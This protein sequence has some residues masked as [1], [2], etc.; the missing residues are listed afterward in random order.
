M[1]LHKLTASMIFDVSY[2][3]VTWDE[4]DPTHWISLGTGRHAMRKWGKEANHALN[5]DMG[6]RTASIRWECT[7]AEAKMIIAAYHRMYPGVRKYQARIR[8]ELNR[9]HSVLA[10]LHGRKRLFMDR[11]GE[12]TWKSAYAFLPQST[13]AAQINKYGLKHIYYQPNRFPEVQL[14]MQIH[15]SI[16]LQ[17]PLVIGWQRIAEILISIK[18]SLETPLVAHGREFVIPADI[19]MRPINFRYG[20]EFKGGTKW[21]ESWNDSKSFGEEMERKYEEV[22]VAA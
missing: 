9:N 12:T 5:Y 22:M 16:R 18:Q 20:A 6:S 17:I 19:K 14:L 2:E 21:D 3:E 10:N 11:W 7:F 13:V 15:D 8:D 4:D 1:D